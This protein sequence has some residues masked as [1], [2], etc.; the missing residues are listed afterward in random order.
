M[1]NKLYIYLNHSPPENGV[2]SCRTIDDKNGIIT[3]I[4]SSKNN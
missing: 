2:L 1:G 3:S 4:L